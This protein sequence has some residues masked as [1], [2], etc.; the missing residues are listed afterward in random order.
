[1]YFYSY[2]PVI[3]NVFT[4][5][6]GWGMRE[7]TAERGGVKCVLRSQDILSFWVGEVTGLLIHISFTPDSRYK[8]N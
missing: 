5:N 8:G 3:S 6:T 4:K 2:R 1:M 7:L